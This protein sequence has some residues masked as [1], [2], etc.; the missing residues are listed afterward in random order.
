MEAQVV[1]KVKKEEKV[2]VEEEYNGNNVR[3][4]WRLK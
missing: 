4:R 1:E 3:K 2:E